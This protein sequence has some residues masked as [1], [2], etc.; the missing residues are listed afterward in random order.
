MEGYLL[1]AEERGEE[2]FPWTVQE[3]KALAPVLSS[4]SRVVRRLRRRL[5]GGYQTDTEMLVSLARTSL[6]R[7]A[8]V[9]VLDGLYGGQPCVRRDDSRRIRRRV[10]MIFSL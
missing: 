3:V 9:P 4:R 6:V 8:V 2:V 7:R 5:S 1:A 10:G